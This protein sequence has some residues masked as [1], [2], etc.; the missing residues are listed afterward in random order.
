MLSRAI[1]ISS[2]TSTKSKDLFMSSCT[3]FW[4]VIFGMKIY[5]HLPLTGKLR[6]NLFWTNKKFVITNFRRKFSSQNII[7]TT[8]KG[9]LSLFN[10]A[11]TCHSWTEIR[12]RQRI[13][14]KAKFACIHILISLD[15]FVVVLT[16][17]QVSSHDT[18]HRQWR[19]Q[20]GLAV[21]KKKWNTVII[22]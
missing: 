10:F 20:W 17:A 4:D 19:L 5:Y 2:R 22:P 6:K 18:D 8:W 1:L 3:L 13:V 9:F 16:V 11:F 12:L 7:P 14:T 21:R 15:F